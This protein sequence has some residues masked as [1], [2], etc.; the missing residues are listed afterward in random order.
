MAA[1]IYEGPVGSASAIKMIRSIMMKGLEAL[2]CECVLAGRKAGVI[3]T[4]LDSLD[5]TYPGF[6]WKK[7]SAYM[8]ERVMTHGVRR[9][10]EMR[11]VALTV[12]LLGLEGAMSRASS[13]G[14]RRSA[15]F[16][17]RT[18]QADAAIIAV[19]ADRILAAT[20]TGKVDRFARRSFASGL[21]RLSV[22]TYREIGARQGARTGGD[23]VDVEMLD[24]AAP[25]W[26]PCLF[27]APG[28]RGRRHRHYRHDP[29]DDRPFGL[30][31]QAGARRPPSSTCSS[32]ATR[33]RARRSI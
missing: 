30:D 20:S 21:R 4:V 8:L 11:E 10:A 15:N 31:R 6:D 27:A 13:A 2:V 23:S 17:L 14:S 33:S 1:K 26:P 9:A 29:A 22:A 24:A 28:A 16:G 32:M 19:L 18:T 12:D 5:D 7:R 3:D 25:R